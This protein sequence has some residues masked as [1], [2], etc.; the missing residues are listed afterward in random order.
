MRG[1]VPLVDSASRALCPRFLL[2]VIAIAPS[3][4][5]QPPSP[6][7][8]KGA[9]CSTTPGLPDLPVTLQGPALHG[10]PLNQWGGNSSVMCCWWEGEL[11]QLLPRT[12]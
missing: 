3:L 5:R 7:G 11:V 1:C 2:P 6:V 9:Q 8:A 10:L 4:P 12:V